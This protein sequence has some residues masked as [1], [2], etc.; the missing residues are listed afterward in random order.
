VEGGDGPGGISAAVGGSGLPSL[1]G[2][3]GLDGR[4]RAS[5][6]RLQKGGKARAGHICTFIYVCIYTYIYIY[7]STYRCRYRYRYMD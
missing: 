5:A 6:G 3:A 2:V 7:N 1:R 4:I